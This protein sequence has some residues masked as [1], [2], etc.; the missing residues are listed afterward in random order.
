METNIQS[1]FYS[2]GSKHDGKHATD[3]GF[4]EEKG[5]E[6]REEI[7]QRTTIYM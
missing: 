5:K 2:L 7:D 6:G 1:A 3:G 4:S